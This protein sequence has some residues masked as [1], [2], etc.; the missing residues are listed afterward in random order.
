MGVVEHD[1]DGIFRTVAKSIGDA[2]R[3]D[4]NIGNK[5]IGL[6]RKQAY[7]PHHSNK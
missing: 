1:T 2:G 5:I 4:E 7:A 3:V 6:D